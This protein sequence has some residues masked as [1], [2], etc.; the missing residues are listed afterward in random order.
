MKVLAEN[1]SAIW[2]YEIKDTFL[3][4]MVLSGAE[5]KSVKNGGASLRGSYVRVLQEAPCLVGAR[6]APY[7]K[8]GDREHDVERTRK[9]LLNKSEISKLSGI[10]SQRGFSLLP[11][12]LIEEDD[13]IKLVVGVGKGRREYDKK[14][15]LKE[16]QEE[17]DT[18][19][20][21]KDVNK[22]PSFSGQ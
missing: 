5:V 11:L 14:R 4:G 21:L 20:A 9:L 10:S 7:K 12:R 1:K 6:I 16:R 15:V 8:S 17:R 22:W 2:N 3:A 18:E 19:R 13:K